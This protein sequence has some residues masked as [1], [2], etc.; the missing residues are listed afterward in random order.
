MGGVYK[1]PIKYLGTDVKTHVC[2]YTYTCACTYT[3]IHTVNTPFSVAF[4]QGDHLELKKLMEAEAEA[5][6][7]QN[8]N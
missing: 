3:C 1:F 4:G 6:Q 2:I 5:T 7:I 8:Q